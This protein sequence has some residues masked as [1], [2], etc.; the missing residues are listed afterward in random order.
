MDTTLI[1]ALAED[2]LATR[3]TFS[4]INELVWSGL[5]VI[6]HNFILLL[7]FYFWYYLHVHRKLRFIFSYLFQQGSRRFVKTPLPHSPQKKD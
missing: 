3:V 7:F 1:S 4:I 6:T 5:I 2:A